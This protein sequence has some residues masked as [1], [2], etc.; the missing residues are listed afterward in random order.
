MNHHTARASNAFME[1]QGFVFPSKTQT[2]QV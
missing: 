1:D 2:Q